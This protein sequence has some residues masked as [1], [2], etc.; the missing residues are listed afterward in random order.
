M[1][2]KKI[3]RLEDRV[4]KLKEQKRRK[5]N[6]RLMLTIGFFFSLMLFVIFF[7]SSLGRITNIQ[8]TGNY[9]VS[10]EDILK[11]T[12]LDESPSY[13]NIS[14]K[15]LEDKLKKNSIIKSVKIEKKFPNKVN[16]TIKEQRTIG[17]INQN[18]TLLPILGNGD[19]LQKAQSPKV[20]NAP[21]IYGFNS[22][23]VA[24][25]YAD[26]LDEL[27]T[28][29]NSILRAIGEVYYQNSTKDSELTLY[30]NDGYTVKITI[31][32]FAKK[33]SDYPAILKVLDPKIK[34]TIYLDVGAYFEPNNNG[35]KQKIE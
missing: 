23:K 18:Q 19:L 6:L 25:D 7:Q 22:D 5:S 2:E 16:V 9:Y 3:I 32:D 26:F 8:I 14:A 27:K 15:D 1:R 13:L 12:G 10:K 11:V 30:M 24:Q 33:I 35:E 31:K 21:I 4:P 28:I 29:P 17:Y 34:G 20:I